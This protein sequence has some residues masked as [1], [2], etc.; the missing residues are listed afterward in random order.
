ME[1]PVDHA[2]HGQQVNGSQRENAMV[3]EQHMEGIRGPALAEVRP[4]DPVL[5]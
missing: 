4:V 1:Q 2:G 3:A 5:R